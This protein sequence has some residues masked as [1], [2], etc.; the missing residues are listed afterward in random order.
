MTDAV[1]RHVSFAQST[2]SISTRTCLLRWLAKLQIL[3]SVCPSVRLVRMEVATTFLT[4]KLD[5]NFLQDRN[6]RCA[7]F[8]F[9]KSNVMAKTY[10]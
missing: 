7:N 1:A 5:V 4:R 3:P 9:E 8:Q 6:D 10:D 2:W